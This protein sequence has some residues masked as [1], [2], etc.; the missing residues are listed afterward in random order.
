MDGKGKFNSEDHYIYYCRQESL[1]RNGVVL[2]INKGIW[3]AVFGC[4]LKNDRIVLFFFP[5]QAIQ[6]HSN[7]SLFPYRICWEAEI[8]RFNED[9]QDFLEL[10]NT[11]YVLFIR[12]DWNAKIESQEIPRVTDKFHFGAQNETGQRLTEFCQ[13]SALV[14]ANTL[15]QQHKGQLYTWTS[16]NGQYRNQIDYICSWRWKQLAKE[17]AKTR[18]GSDCGSDHQLLTE[19]LR[20]KSKKVGKTTR[21]FR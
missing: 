12:K 17:L 2:I 15:F 14:I 16:P 13:E 8:D 10:T 1:T 3:N 19:K 5:R 6:Y 7:P 11:K 18:P 20:L 4:N 9:L 21:P